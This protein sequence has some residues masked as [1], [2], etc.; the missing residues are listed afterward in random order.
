MTTSTM[1]S[2]HLVLSAIL[3]LQW[4]VA[5]TAAFQSARTPTG[6]QQRLRVQL[7]RQQ[8]QVGY[9]RASVVLD[10]NERSDAER[11]L[12]KAKAIRDSLPDTAAATNNGES[13]SNSN[14]PTKATRQEANRVVSKFSLPSPQSSNNNFR[15]Y[16]DIG[17]E[18][19]TWMDPRWG[20]SGRRIEC[21]LD[22]TFPT[23]SSSA[24]EEDATTIRQPASEEITAGLIKTV[25]TKSSTL[26]PVF[27]LQSAPFARLRGGFDEMKIIDGGYCVEYSASASLS[28]SSTLRFCIEVVGTTD[29]DVT[30]PEGKLYF[31]LPYFGLRT[32]RGG[33]GGDDSTSMSKMEVSNREGTMTVKQMGWHTGWYREESRMLGVFR[34]V[35]LEKARGRDKF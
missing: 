29:L 9:G 17:R 18:S 31:A 16:L 1:T 10:A 14:D 24:T 27:K 19:G 28:S 7:N 35:P 23:P 34:A 3:L 30:I 11:L 13:T 15:L 2:L 12:A 8:Q 32:E 20:A 6:D 5:L 21:T 25:T 26:S 4:N 22:I 33:D